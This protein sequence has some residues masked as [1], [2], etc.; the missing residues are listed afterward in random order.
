MASSST[1]SVSVMSK[2]HAAGKIAPITIIRGVIVIG[3]VVLLGVAGEK[4]AP[5]LPEMEAWVEKQGAWGPIYLVIFGLALS[6]FCLPLDLLSLAG[7]A[8][9]GLKTGMIYTLLA[10]FIGQCVAYGIGRYVM[11]E[12]LLLWAET[13]PKLQRVRQ[14]TRQTHPLMLIA[15]RAS[16]LPASPLA[17]LMGASRVSFRTFLIGSLGM[18]PQA[19]VMVFFGYASVHTTRLL[20]DP[21]HATL[22]HNIILYGS[23]LVAVIVV[24]W[25]AHRARKLLWTN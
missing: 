1:Q 24:A 17:Y 25:L 14:A 2:L 18:I 21:G 5:H 9:F 3:V 10:L 13:R 7:G 23:L 22:K 6:V 19:L 8:V 16:P 20:H 12:R 4:L 11:G 15:L